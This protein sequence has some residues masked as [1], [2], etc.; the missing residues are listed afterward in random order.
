V[1]VEVR[2]PHQRFRTD[3]EG[4]TTWHSFSFGSHYDPTN[5]GFA[6]LVALN[7]ENLPRHN[8]YAPHPH[9]G[10]E[11]VTLVLD[12]ALEHRSDVGSGV[13]TPGGVQRLS[14]G[15]GVIHAE[16]NA[17]TGPTRFLQAWVSSD[18]PEREPEYLSGRV[19]TSTGWS[20]IAGGGDSVLPI[21]AAMEM[22]VANPDAGQE[23]QL[24]DRSAML[25]HVATGSIR[26]AGSAI[27]AGGEIRLMD[28]GGRN[29]HCIS[30][31]T[32]LALWAV[33]PVGR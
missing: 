4:R 2:G 31:D 20:L 21:R 15:R 23:L 30:P 11:I 17:S 19:G 25:L 9:Q 3:A 14:A 7:E 10:L 5:T 24:P 1:S 26:L 29:L 27:S 6:Q 18:Q 33:S 32:T 16:L 8:G 22:W 28:E 13:I 12:G